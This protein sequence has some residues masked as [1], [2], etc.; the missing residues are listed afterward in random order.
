MSDAFPVQQNWFKLVEKIGEDAARA[1]LA[2]WLR[3]AASR[4][5]GGGFPDVFGCEIPEDNWEQQGPIAKVVVILS[6]PWGG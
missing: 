6:N 5:E 4:V 1:K 3:W 2:N